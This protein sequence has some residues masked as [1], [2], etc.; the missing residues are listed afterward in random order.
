MKRKSL[1][2]AL[3]AVVLVA[4]M[5]I[6]P[7]WAYFTDTSTDRVSFDRF[8]LVYRN[9]AARINHRIPLHKILSVDLP[10]FS[11]HHTAAAACRE[12]YPFNIFK[13]IKL[14]HFS[15]LFPDFPDPFTETVNQ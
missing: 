3:V 6:A 11:V 9:T 10:V 2:F 5:G 13:N 1:W 8:M 12:F 14:F 4:A 7:A 15:D